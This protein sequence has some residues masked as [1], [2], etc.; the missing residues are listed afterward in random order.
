MHL[1]EFLTKRPQN[2]LL[3]LGFQACHQGLTDPACITENEPSPTSC[4][5][6]FR[7]RGQCFTGQWLPADF[8]EPVVPPFLSTFFVVD[9]V[10]FTLERISG[11]N[12][13]PPPIILF[14]T[15]PVYRQAL[16]IQMPKAVQYLCPIRL[17]LP[18]TGQPHPS[19]R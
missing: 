3:S 7:G 2:D 9:P 11:Q 4:R 5:G 15:A 14:K 16:H 8:I 6:P 19:A 13:F 10:A 17:P 12:H 1:G 18:Q